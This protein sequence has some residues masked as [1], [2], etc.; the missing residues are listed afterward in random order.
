[1][2]KGTI[3]VDFISD[4][5]G[6]KA[7]AR[8]DDRINE[9]V[10]QKNILEVLQKSIG[11][12]TFISGKVKKYDNGASKFR[13]TLKEDDGKKGTIIIN[14]NPQ[15]HDE[16]DVNV[17]ELEAVSERGNSIKYWNRTKM[18]ATLILVPS[19]TLGSIGLA[20]YEAYKF[21]DK[22]LE[23]EQTQSVDYVQEL[24]KAREENGIYPIQWNESDIDEFERDRSQALAEYAEN[25]I[26]YN[27]G[28]YFEEEQE[29]GKIR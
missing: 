15:Y 28:D 4:S 26:S 11:K 13:Y 12:G 9:N 24:N 16:N 8:Q 21:V 5:I 23:E 2:R 27:F 14:T 7:I 6:D 1:M 25:E 20:G 18:A 22:M 29:K 19:V 3:I 17:K 10:S